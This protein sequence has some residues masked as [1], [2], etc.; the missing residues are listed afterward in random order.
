MDR[1]KLM[2]SRRTHRKLNTS[3]DNGQV[4]PSNVLARISP[5]NWKEGWME[6]SFKKSREDLIYLSLL[7]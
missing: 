4:L 3:E 7:L 5:I 1:E 2:G 6:Q